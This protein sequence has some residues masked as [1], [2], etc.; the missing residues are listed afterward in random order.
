[1]LRI[2]S[3]ITILSSII[4]LVVPGISVTIAFSLLASI[5]R[6][7]DLPALG[8]PTITVLIPSLRRIPLLLLA[9]SSST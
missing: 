3:L 8:L 7:D 6:S 9:I 2:I 5:L 1:M 4:S